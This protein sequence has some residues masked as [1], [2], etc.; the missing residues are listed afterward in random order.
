[1][2]AVTVLVLLGAVAVHDLQ[3]LRAPNRFVY[4]LAGLA[5][6]LSVTAFRAHAIEAFLGAAIAFGS[7][8]LLALLG[9]GS[10]GYGDVKYSLIC[11]LVVGVS[12]VFSMLSFAFVVA[13]LTAAIVLSTRIR[14]RGEVI[15]FTPFLFGGVLFALVTS[16]R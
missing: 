10:L 16:P 1:M 12:R 6:V 2:V 14:G 11:G 15:A 7:L 9:R 3:T 4:P 13:G 8:L 5:M